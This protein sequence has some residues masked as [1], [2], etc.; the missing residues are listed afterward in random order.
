MNRG[1]TSKTLS[2]I[3]WGAWVLLFA[4]I[5]TVRL[6]W[7]PVGPG[8]LIVSTSAAIITIYGLLTSPVVFYKTLFRKPLAGRTLSRCLLGLMPVVVFLLSVGVEGLQAPAIHD[9]TTDVENPPQFVL[10]ASDRVE[11]DHSVDYEGEVIARLQQRAYPDITSRT[12]EKSA[13]T[14]KVA[15]LAAIDELEWRTLG[16][17]S[18]DTGGFRIEAVDRSLMFGFEDDVVIR[19]SPQGNG[20]RLDVRSASRLGLGDLGAN[21]KRIRGFFETL[22]ENS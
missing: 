4:G 17:E 11:G 9:I 2:W 21:A 13:D 5:A 15:V 1:R 10:A 22:G 16:V 12:Y 7:L 14:M 8:L 6:S 19:V 18:I 20:T 3:F